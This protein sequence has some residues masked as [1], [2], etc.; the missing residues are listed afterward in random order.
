MTIPAALR[1]LLL[2]PALALSALPVIVPASSD[3]RFDDKT[4][5]F[6]IVFHGERS[7]YRD[8]S[9]AVMPGEAVTFDTAGPAGEY[10]VKTDHGIAVQQSARRFRWT[11][12]ERPG[13][14]RLTFRGP[15]KKDAHDD[16]VLHAFVMVPAT[17]VKNGFLNG[18]RIGEYPSTP[19]KGNPL[20]LP[21]RG[22]IEVTGDNQDTKVSPHFTLKQFLCKQDMTRAFPKYVLLKERLPLKLEAVL[23][24]VNQLGFKADTLNVMSAYRTPYYNHAIG[25]VMYSM[26]QWG[27]AADVYVDPHAKNRME[28]LNRDS[29]VD[30]NDAKFLYDEI[31]QMLSAKEL[32]RFQGG[33]GYYP[34]TSAHPPFVHV[35]VRG[36]AARWKG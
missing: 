19:L 35:D 5:G 23:E 32:R 27:S 4:A 30:I 2:A 31:E 1:A 24:R 12:P 36:T 25:D 6:A 8:A 26:H 17:Q 11:A 21:P 16:I 20:Y 29:R 22:F 7:A 10:A 13:T 18:Y 9:V 33:M 3:D 15:G 14:Y 28:D 34:A